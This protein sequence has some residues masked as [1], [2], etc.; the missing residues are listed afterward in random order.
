MSVISGTV[1]LPNGRLVNAWWV[2]EVSD[3]AER[4]AD[5]AGCPIRETYRLIAQIA[6]ARDL[7]EGT[8]DGE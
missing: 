4:M 5:E 7:G 3:I 2:T 8:T 1:R 6:T